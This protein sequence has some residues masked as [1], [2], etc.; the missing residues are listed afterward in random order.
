MKVKL[1]N[2]LEESI[3]QNFVASTNRRV[4]QLR[5]DRQHCLLHLQDKSLSQYL[6][7]HKI[8]E[9]NF[10]ATERGWEA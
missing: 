8:A 2:N 5:L 4:L 10:P 9:T 1:V 7:W 3:Q 6:F